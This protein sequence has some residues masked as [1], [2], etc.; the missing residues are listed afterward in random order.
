QLLFE[1]CKIKT[2]N[3]VLFYKYIWIQGR[4]WATLG[5]RSCL[6][7]VVSLSHQAD[8]TGVIG[9]DVMTGVFT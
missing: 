7:V 1:L 4:R 9:L 6:R 2:G 8:E 3:S 5:G